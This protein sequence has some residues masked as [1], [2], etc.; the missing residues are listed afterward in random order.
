MKLNVKA[1]SIASGIVIGLASLFVGEA[2]V[3]TG[4]GLDYVNIAGPLHPGYSPTPLGAL[5][6]AIW[7]FIYGLIGGALIA[8]IYNRF[9]GPDMK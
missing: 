3:F 5:I 9:A 2:A 4:I 1:L 7:M 6:M 8:A